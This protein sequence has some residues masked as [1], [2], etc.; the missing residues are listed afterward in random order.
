[1][2][3]KLKLYTAIVLIHNSKIHKHC[4]LR[5]RD[6][7]YRVQKCVTTWRHYSPSVSA[8]DG[9]MRIIGDYIGQKPL[10]CDYTLFQNYYEWTYEM[11]DATQVAFYY[12]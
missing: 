4:D 1:M 11:N 3:G 2:E 7:E 5:V 8:R 9:P 10:Q 6:Y 12:Y